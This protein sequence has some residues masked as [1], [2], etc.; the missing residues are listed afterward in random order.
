M[1]TAWTQRS[2]AP[3]VSIGL[4][5]VGLIFIFLGSCFQHMT[6]RD[7]G[8]QLLIV[9]GPVPLFR[10]RIDYTQITSVEASRSAMI[11]GFGIHYVPGRGWTYNLWGFSC[12]ELHLGKRIIRVGS[13]DVDG[14][15]RFLRQAMG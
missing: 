7:E 15:V 13:D 10:K 3:A 5:F 4:L 6:V 11:D 12:A 2:T 9:Y 1:V 8:A 14:L